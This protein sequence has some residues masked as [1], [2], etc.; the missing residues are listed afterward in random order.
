MYL[1]KT[2]AFLQWLY[3]QLIWHRSRKEPVVYLTFDD[4]PVPVT[5][6]YI[7]D[8]LKSYGVQATFFCVGENI[9]K[10]PELFTR[11]IDEGHSI[12]NH[13]M[14]HLNGWK[15]DNSNYLEDVGQCAATIRLHGRLSDLFRPPYGK[16]TRR[17]IRE[18]GDQR[19][20]MWDVLSGDFD[21]SL[22]P[23]RCL[24]KTLKA[25]RPGSV[26][27]FHDNP[28]AQEKLEYVL[29]RV[30]DYL[31]QNKLEVRAL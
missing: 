27:V 15:N 22:S 3:P 7:L 14:H 4:G 10:Y 6:T 17:Q 21:P 25:I 12:G 28:K 19:I 23:E 8:L 29:P 20:I 11:L 24:R 18:L 9:L 2:P 1:H 5:T 16:I 13:T 31:K 30:L 26:I